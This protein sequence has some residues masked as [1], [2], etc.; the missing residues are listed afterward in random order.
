MGVTTTV[1]CAALE[2][3]YEGSLSPPRSSHFVPNLLYQV[4]QSKQ[5]RSSD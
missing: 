5:Q 4:H 1:T 3:T 2:A